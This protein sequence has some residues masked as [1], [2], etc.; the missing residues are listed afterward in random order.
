MK[1]MNHS[2]RLRLIVE[3]GHLDHSPLA[4]GD[5]RS[6]AERIDWLED[7]TNEQAMLIESQEA[8]IKR[9]KVDIE[10]LRHTLQRIASLD[11][12]EGDPWAACDLAHQVLSADGGE[13]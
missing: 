10:R 5:V 2:E 1:A 4:M 6:I 13:S 9:L 8:K 3:D 11:D 12:P 7:T